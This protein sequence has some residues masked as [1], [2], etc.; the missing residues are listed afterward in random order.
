MMTKR[1]FLIFL[2]M[3]FGFITR[4]QF[5]VVAYLPN[6]S[7]DLHKHINAFDFTKITH[8]NLAFFNPDENGDFPEWQSAGVN[9][10]VTKAH[11]N[12]VKV[13]LSL[14]GGSDQSQYAKLLMPENR[15]AFITKV[16]ALLAQ[17]KADG[18]DVDIEG[19][20]I[21]ANYEAFV[22]ELSALLKAKGKLITGAVA[23]GTRTK[24]TD[25]CLKAYDFINVMSYG[26]NIQSHAAIE[27]ARQHIDYWKGVRSLP[28]SKIVIGIAFYARYDTEKSFVTIKY[29]DLLKQYPGAERKDYIKRNEDGLVISYHNAENTKNRTAL[30]LSECGGIMI[31]QVLQDATGDSSLLKAIDDKIHETK[32]WKTPYITWKYDL[33]TGSGNGAE[34]FNSASAENVSVSQKTAS[35]GFL[36]YPF[37]GIARV[38]LP[39]N[40]GGSFMLLTDKD[41]TKIEITAAS[42]GS[43]GKLSWYNV[44]EATPLTTVAFT[45]KLDAPLTNGQLIIPFGKGTTVNSTFNNGSQLTS[46][47][48]PGVFGALRLDFYAG[49]FATASYR[50][51]S[52][53]Y[54]SIKNNVFNKTGTYKVELYCNN[55]TISRAYVKG[56]QTYTIPPQTFNLWVNGVLIQ[57]AGALVNFP[58]T[59][60]LAAN[61]VINSF[62]FNTSGNTGTPASVPVT[63]PNSLKAIL[64]GI[65]MTFA[66]ILN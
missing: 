6:F 24:I 57:G 11:K 28:A 44:T 56:T 63:K 40:S 43:A 15:A 34:S 2:L 25:A 39:R 13:L 45:L 3:S 50:N 54:N 9:E 10:V 49:N 17:F 26:R 48:T 60:E 16:M 27:Y 59:G 19:K 36:P 35:G 64:S 33:G 65:S 55:N 52:Y 58:A 14:A 5:K 37:H 20:N 31:W 38:S 51:S 1:V 41:T 30:A 47:Q 61:E 62:T 4:A 22:L 18:I 32:G 29:G 8:L 42:T 46:V 66:S 21:D 12:K 7:K 53:T 23:W